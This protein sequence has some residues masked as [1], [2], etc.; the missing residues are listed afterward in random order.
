MPRHSTSL[1]TSQLKGTS[2]A[3]ASL[4]IAPAQHMTPFRGH[5]NEFANLFLHRTAHCADYVRVVQLA[6]RRVNGAL[7]DTMRAM[8]MVAPAQLGLFVKGVRERPMHLKTL[9]YTSLQ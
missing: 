2:T 9:S 8:A 3:T 7:R 6:M 1:T 5:V 4:P